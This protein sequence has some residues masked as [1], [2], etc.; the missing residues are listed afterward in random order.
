[1]AVTGGAV[2]GG[3]IGYLLGQLLSPAPWRPAREGA[4]S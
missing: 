1:M 3:L 2:G 4:G